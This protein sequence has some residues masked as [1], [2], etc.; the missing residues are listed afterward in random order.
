MNY[1]NLILF[2]TVYDTPVFRLSLKS[3]VETAPEDTEIIVL[4]DGLFSDRKC[5][6][7]TNSLE[8]NCGLHYLKYPHHNSMGQMFKWAL[9]EA[10]NYFD[11]LSCFSHIILSHND[12]YF[13][14]DWSITLNEAIARMASSG[15][16]E[17]CPVINLSHK[18]YSFKNWTVPPDI[19][20]EELH[21]QLEQFLFYNAKIDSFFGVSQ[22]R[23]NINRVG[24]LSPFIC[25]N[26]EWF[27][28]TSFKDTGHGYDCEIL[29]DLSRN[30]YWSIWINNTR[31]LHFRPTESGNDTVLNHKTGK[32]ADHYNW[33]DKNVKKCEEIFGVNLEQWLDIEFGMIKQLHKEEIEDVFNNHL[34][35]LPSLDYIFDEIKDALA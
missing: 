15:M 1:N 27:L 13:P 33:M 35:E 29:W 22:D 5:L 30:R 23:W 17:K 7:F 4:E 25:I 8:S 28:D 6:E 10:D 14:P 12:L 2:S 9:D 20:Y 3:L 21:K 31:L 26:R 34:S 16:S 32:A 19:S 11:G 24:R 18:E